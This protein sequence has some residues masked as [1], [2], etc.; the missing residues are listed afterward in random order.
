MDRLA[1]R[2]H[3]TLEIAFIRRD[4]HPPGKKVARVKAADRLHMGKP[5]VRHVGHEKADL[6][7]MTEQHNLLGSGLSGSFAA[8]PP[9]QQRPHRING[10]LVEQAFDFR[11]DQLADTV[12]VARHSGGFAKTAKQIDIHGRSCWGIENTPILEPFAPRLKGAGRYIFHR[13]LTTCVPKPKNRTALFRFAIAVS[14][15]MTNI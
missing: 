12:F 5:L 3:H 9:A 2:I 6:V 8:V 10:D 15:L 13:V 4:Q 1:A 7:H 11:L 14:Q